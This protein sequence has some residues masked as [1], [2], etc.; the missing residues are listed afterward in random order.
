M[1]KILGKVNYKTYFAFLSHYFCKT[2]Y[3]FIKYIVI[4]ESEFFQKYVRCIYFFCYL[5]VKPREQTK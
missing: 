3:L 1:E 4:F 2:F 5:F